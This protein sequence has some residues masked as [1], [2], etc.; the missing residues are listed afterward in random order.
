M[1]KKPGVA[2]NEPYSHN[3]D[4][5]VYYELKFE[6]DII[7]PG[8]L[9]KFKNVRG[10]FRFIKWVH[11]LHLDVTWVDCMDTAS[12]EW[13]SMYISRIKGVVKPKR[14]RRDKPNV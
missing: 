13:K 7:K 14:S 2:I 3:D 9:L 11:N 12:G 8:D 1:K 4:I 5:S 6:K 10:T